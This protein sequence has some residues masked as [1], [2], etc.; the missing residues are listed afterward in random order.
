MPEDK[1]RD[2]CQRVES[3]EELLRKAAGDEWEV[4][5]RINIIEQRMDEMVAGRGDE[6]LAEVE[7]HLA[8]VDLFALEQ[9]VAR[10]EERLDEQRERQQE[11]VQA[12]KDD[13]EELIRVNDREHADLRG[14]IENMQSKF[15]LQA[16]SLIELNELMSEERGER[17]E[18]GELWEE[19]LEALRTELAEKDATLRQLAGEQTDGEN[20]MEAA[21]RQLNQLRAELEDLA[22]LA[23]RPSPADQF[24]GCVVG[25]A[26]IS[27]LVWLAIKV[28]SWISGMLH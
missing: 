25:L 26:L 15:Q 2:L 10:L 9:K 24:L 27:G 1:L 19:S 13:D 14:E 18:Q 7:A 21:E 16:D 11:E 22:Q 23:A 5:D 4:A 6:R 8:E 28:F 20:R 17:V 12:I 3:L